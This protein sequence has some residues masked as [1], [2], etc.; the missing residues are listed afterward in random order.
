MKNRILVLC[1]F[2]I[3][4]S[5][6][7]SQIRNTKITNRTKTVVST[8]GDT[9]LIKAESLTA[10]WK[11]AYTHVISV[12]SQANLKAF[13]RLEKLLRESSRQYNPENTLIICT[14]KYL[15]FI[16]EAATGFKILQLCG[17]EFP[18]VMLIEGT[19]VP[20]TKEDNEP[21]YDFKF[22]KTKTL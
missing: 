9:S 6:A 7:Y 4:A 14:G 10:V 20:L 11:P 17:M 18:D 22:V 2:C 8:F 19:I 1:L 5:F 13:I 3:I 12:S 15:E 16:E 21:D